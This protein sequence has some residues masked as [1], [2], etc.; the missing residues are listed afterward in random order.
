MGGYGS[1]R[2]W[3]GCKSTT[4]ECRQIDVRRW[5]RQGKLAAGQWLTCTWSR[6][7]EVTGN[8]SAT[9]E[10]DRVIL[11]YRHCRGDDNWQQHKYPVLLDWT[12]C[13]Y[14]GQRAWFLC[15]ARGCGRRVA[16][17]YLGGSV[18]ACRHCYQL[19]YNSQR[20][21]PYMRAL[22]RAQAIREKL[23]GSGSMAEPFPWKPKGMHW[24]TYSRLALAAR[25]AESRS[26]PD[27][28]NRLVPARSN[29]H[30]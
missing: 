30:R 13:H 8:I 23:G 18:F 25:E 9:V 12:S 21:P 24:T 3:S 20:D 10:M 29:A 1:G 4:S 5:Q 15:P 17:L 22:S 14:G 16:I 27:W 6:N 19:S 28:I 26:W 2:R 11:S 7:S